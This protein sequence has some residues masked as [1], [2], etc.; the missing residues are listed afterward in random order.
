MLLFANVISVITDQNHDGVCGVRAGVQGIQDPA[1]L[2]VHIRGAGQVSARGMD[3][4]VVGDNALMLKTEQRT[5]F[6]WNVILIVGVDRCQDHLFQWIHIEIFLWRVPGVM[7]VE[8]PESEQEGLLGVA[9]V[10]NR[11]HGVV[12]KIGIHHVGLLN[13]ADIV[14]VIDHTPVLFRTVLPPPFQWQSIGAAWQRRITGAVIATDLAVKEIPRH[15]PAV[16]N[17][18]A[19]GGVIPRVVK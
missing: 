16:V 7:R 18:A 11:I 5:A 1:D 14:R 10:G 2:G 6:F 12:G 19:F 15:I 9:V 17:L 4:I 13:R 8:K 3:R